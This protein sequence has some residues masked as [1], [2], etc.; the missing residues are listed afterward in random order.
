MI[1]KGRCDGGF[2]WNPSICECDKSCDIGEY[3]D[4]ENYKCTKR[5][6]DKLIEDCSEDING[7]DT[8]YNV[9]LNDHGRVCMQLLYIIHSTIN[10]NFH[11]NYVH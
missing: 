6:I 11:N 9:T 2:I 4:H 1:D 10:H 5:S 8:I 3:L 7:N